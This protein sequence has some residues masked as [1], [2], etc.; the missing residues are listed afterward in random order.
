MNSIKNAVVV[1]L[2]L[3]VAYGSF[4]I[5]NTPDPNGEDQAT[6]DAIDQGI[7]LE[8]PPTDPIQQNFNEF[9]NDFKEKASLTPSEKEKLEKNRVKKKIRVL[10][11]ILVE[12]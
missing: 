2:L 11:F 3:G 9:K 10:R 1:V 4:K 5:I 12:L 7:N 8:I 6:L